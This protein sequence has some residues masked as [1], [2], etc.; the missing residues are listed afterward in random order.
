MQKSDGNITVYISNDTNVDEGSLWHPLL[1]FD[2]LKWSILY[3]PG[4]CF[5]GSQ[6]LHGDISR[7][8]CVCM[9]RNVTEKFCKGTLGQK[10]TRGLS[11]VNH[12][13]YLE[14]CDYDQCYSFFMNV[15]YDNETRNALF[16]CSSPV[17]LDE[18][19][20]LAP[21][22]VELTFPFPFS[23]NRSVCNESP[24]L[25]ENVT[26]IPT[27]YVYLY[28][29]PIDPYGYSSQPR[30]QLIL[31]FDKNAQLIADGYKFQ[32]NESQGNCSSL[33]RS[34]QR[35]CF[36]ATDECAKSICTTNSRQHFD[37]EFYS[38]GDQY[39]H[40]FGN[41]TTD[42]LNEYY[43]KMNTN[44]VTSIAW[45]WCRSASLFINGKNQSNIHFA[46]GT[47]SILSKPEEMNFLHPTMCKD[48]EY[49]LNIQKAVNSTNITVYVSNDTNVDEG[50]L[51]HPLLVFD[52][53]KWSRLYKPGECF[54]ESQLLHGDISRQ[55]CVC[56]RRNVT[57]KFCKGTLGQKPTRGLS[58]VTDEALSEEPHTY[59]YDASTETSITHSE[60]EIRFDETFNNSSM[61][62]ENVCDTIETISQQKN[63]SQEVVTS[64]L[65]K[66][67][68]LTSNASMN[69][70]PR[71]ASRLLTSLNSLMKNSPSDIDFKD[72]ESFAVRRT[73]VNCSMA[74]S[75]Q[76]WPI[77]KDVIRYPE[78]LA[79]EHRIS[80]EIPR[81][82][83]C[84][85]SEKQEFIIVY[86]VFHNQ[87]LFSSNDNDRNPCD[88]SM[89]VPKEASVVSATLLK[90]W[91]MEEVHRIPNNGGHKIMARIVYPA[92]SVKNPLHGSVKLAYW[93]GTD[94]VVSD[95]AEMRTFGNYYQYDI[96]H[97]TDF[98]LI[99]DGLEMDPILCNAVL[100]VFSITLNF[101]SFGGLLVLIACMMV[102]W[103]IP[104]GNYWDKVRRKRVNQREDRIRFVHYVTLALF[105]F[106]F[107]MF[108][109]S[110]DLF[111]PISCEIAAMMN[112]A[113]L[114]GC[115]CITTLQFMN[116]M[117]IDMRSQ[118][119]ERIIRCASGKWHI[120]L[121]GIGGPIS[122]VILLSVF[123]PGFFTR[124]D[125][126]CWIR[127]DYVV[128]AV[129]VPLSLVV[130]NAIIGLVKISMRTMPQGKVSGVS[131]KAS[132]VTAT[133]ILLLCMQ[134]MLGA[135]WICQ[136]FA[137]S[138][139]NLVVS[140]Y[141]FTITIGS[142]G[143]LFFVL[144][145]Y[146]KLN[147]YCLQYF[148]SKS[149]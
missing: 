138:A 87:A 142:Q 133:V 134:L 127:P 121:I 105:H 145:C 119:L 124:K 42:H 35:A 130:I 77:M 20:I 72:G 49:L 13:G 15:T 91:N 113:L 51:W 109:D 63:I 40:F 123:M 38:S 37:P 39:Y 11:Q 47:N 99:V 41:W 103:L 32:F 52:W 129:V 18:D 82:T 2:W 3:K 92:E 74:D 21:A 93:T 66:L 128:P 19:E 137:L 136:Y 9:R 34:K 95:V 102:K 112:Y 120:I 111:W 89:H 100:N 86:Y 116:T 81:K 131:F 78:N 126:F 75:A 62:L 29:T 46:Y 148:H 17:P 84:N 12:Y 14:L 36:C 139:P 1:V 65:T 6:L 48:S 73:S 122:S 146:R 83:V 76:E 90:K 31:S 58:Q 4:E 140:H 147:I 135:P 7:Q 27:R 45:L 88:P 125:S 59:S 23:K 28:L 71:M 144:F 106:C 43:F 114:L 55:F 8:F 107:A 5:Y 57:E 117:N 54:Y 24:L 69:I 70:T 96:G 10:P 104:N 64:V 141:I 110:R 108:V 118:A 149:L 79:A 97:L 53:L 67:D 22:N 60:S 33:D 98:T 56:M 16:S 68:E 25:L 50:S 132:V 115:I 44:N 85:E 94:W 80:I 143:L 101:F 61:S 30:L 26:F